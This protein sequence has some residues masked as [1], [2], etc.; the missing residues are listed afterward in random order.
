MEMEINSRT[1]L[2]MV[3]RY[4][5]L[6]CSNIKERLKLQKLVYLLQSKGLNLG[7]A[8]NWY[9]H[10][11]YSQTL[12]DDAFTVLNA[13]RDKYKITE[14][15]NFNNTTEQKLKAIRTFLSPNIHNYRLLELVASIDFMDRIWGES[16]EC[17]QNIEKLKKRK[18]IL[19]D[20]KPAKDKEIKDA[21]VLWKKFKNV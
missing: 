11:P 2:S 21:I 7:Y 6:K 13:D 12:A 3:S 5:D 18:N 15:W 14:R 16:C 4:F 8:Y 20:G 19:I 17:E 10:G 1:V 9:K